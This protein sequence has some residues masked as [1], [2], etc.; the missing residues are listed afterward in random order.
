MPHRNRE[1]REIDDVRERKM[2]KKKT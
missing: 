2:P 1:F